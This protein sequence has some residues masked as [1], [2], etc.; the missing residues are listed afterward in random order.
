MF[1]RTFVVKSDYKFIMMRAKRLILSFEMKTQSSQKFFCVLIRSSEK[2][3][4]KKS[5]Y[6]IKDRQFVRQDRPD[7][8]FFKIILSD[9]T[10]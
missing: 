10:Q 6:R 4:T 3:L 9:L 7:K 8:I 5:H 1:I 2:I